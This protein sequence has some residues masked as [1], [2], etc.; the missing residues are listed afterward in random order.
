MII[1]SLVLV[2]IEEF[3]SFFNFLLLFIGEFSALSSLRFLQT[4]L[5][6]QRQ[7]HGFSLNL[8]TVI[9]IKLKY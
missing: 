7:T 9:K 1:N 5:I 3:K 8:H 4:K 6:S 2:C